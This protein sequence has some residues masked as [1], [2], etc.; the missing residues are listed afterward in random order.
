ML[1]VHENKNIGLW[2]SFDILI[3]YKESN[4][5]KEKK[6]NYAAQH[7]KC[8][9]LNHHGAK[10]HEVSISSNNWTASGILVATQWP[11]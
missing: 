9:K 11:S 5:A 2:E 1:S 6:K 10:M 7:E 3:C 8:K 4:T